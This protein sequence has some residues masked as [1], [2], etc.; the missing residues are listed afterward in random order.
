MTD[1]LYGFPTPLG[2]I[3]PELAMIGLVA[4]FVFV[5]VALII[6]GRKDNK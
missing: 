6:K 2:Q 1:T 3:S 4:I 5:V